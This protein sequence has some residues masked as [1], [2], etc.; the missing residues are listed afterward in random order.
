LSRSCAAHKTHYLS[1][2]EYDHQLS[3]VGL[4]T[5]SLKKKHT[6][7][8]ACIFITPTYTNVRENN[9]AAKLTVKFGRGLGGALC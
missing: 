4:F 7:A 2:K 6:A 9:T 1:I 3:G 5:L 8:F